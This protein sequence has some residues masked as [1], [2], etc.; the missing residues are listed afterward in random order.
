MIEFELI[1]GRTKRKQTNCFDWLSQKEGKNIMFI[2]DF[3]IGSGQAI[4]CL[5]SNTVLANNKT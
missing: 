5:S 4:V 3:I 2:S 1:E